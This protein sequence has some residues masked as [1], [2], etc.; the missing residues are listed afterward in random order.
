MKILKEEIG[1]NYHTL[2][3]DPYTWENYA[4]VEVE[5]YANAEDSTYSAI[6][7]CIS[8]PELSTKERKFPD[9]HSAKHWARMNAEQIMR[10]TLNELRILVRE[11]IKEEFKL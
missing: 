4:D 10:A 3:N 6:V 9:E 7:K 2:D 8:R 11:L 5:T 1:R